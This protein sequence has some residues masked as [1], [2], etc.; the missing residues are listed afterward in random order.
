MFQNIGKALL[1]LVFLYASGALAEALERL[2]DRVRSAGDDML[3]N[4]EVSYVYGGNKV[5]DVKTCEQCNQCLEAKQP[6]PKERFKICAVCGGCSLDCSHFVQLVFARAG[7]SFPY[8]TSTQMLDL[9]AETLERRYQLRPVNTAASRSDADVMPGD[10]L[11]YRGHVVIVEAF[12]GNGQ[13]DIIHATGGRDIREPGQGIQ[14]ERF[15]TIEHFRGPLLR[16]LRHVKFHALRGQS[17]ATSSSL[18]PSLSPSL[19]G[20]S[21]ASTARFKLRPVEKR[22]VE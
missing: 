17:V 10:L 3:E 8:L 16:V 5:G 12:H 11:V 4:L 7:L 9:N 6:A 20:S 14:R 18:S 1:I 19:Q 21:G 2:Q 13:A 22:R 15:V